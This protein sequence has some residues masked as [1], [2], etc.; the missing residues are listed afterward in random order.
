MDARIE[1]NER[2]GGRGAKRKKRGKE[3][4]KEGKSSG[5]VLRKEEEREGRELGGLVGGCKWR[6]IRSMWEK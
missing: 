1:Y 2:S 5:C 4:K 6:G 3:G